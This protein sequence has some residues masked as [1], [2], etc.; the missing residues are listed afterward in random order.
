MEIL[1]SLKEKPPRKMSFLAA[2]KVL[3]EDYTVQ[4]GGAILVVGL[5]FT[6][7]SVGQ[8]EFMEV[9][10]ISGDW[11]QTSGRVVESSAIKDDFWRFKFEITVEGKMYEG[12]SYGLLSE[13]EVRN[14]IV[15]YRTFNPRRS[16]IVGSSAEL[17]PALA[18][19]CL[20]APLLGLII[21]LIGLKKQFR[22]L[23]LLKYGIV[24]QGKTLS[25]TPVTAAGGGRAYRFVF[26][27]NVNDKS[28]EATC[29]SKEMETV[30]DDNLYNVLYNEKNPSKNI[31]YD[32]LGH[33]PEIGQLRDIKEGNPAATFYVGLTIIGFIA[34]LYLYYL[35][36]W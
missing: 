15:E 36:Y 11:E 12:I 23:Y 20:L 16:R 1:D 30:E 8:S 10:N 3:F 32:A 21:L 28:Y 31:V 29:I 24:S 17:F 2:I 19:Y 26:E 27:F 5:F 13:E 33:V 4:V 6:Q 9:I 35:W 7:L 25:V 22:A 34:N 18:G 14:C